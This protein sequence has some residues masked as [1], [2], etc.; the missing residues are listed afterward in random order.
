MRTA[1]ISPAILLLAAVACAEPEPAPESGARRTAEA[2]VVD[3][4]W[5]AELRRAMVRRQI[6]A[7]GVR[8]E[9]VLRAMRTVPR[10]RFVPGADAASA[11]G[12]RP[13]PIGHGQTISQPYIVAFMAEAADIEPGDRVLEIGTGS[14]YGAAV[15]AELAGEVYTIEIVPELAARAGEVLAREGY[16]NVHVRAGNGWLGW[17][18]HAP[19]DAIVV[20]AAPERVPPA[21]VEQLA[22]GGALVIPVGDWVQ[23]LRVLRKTPDGLREEASLPVRFVPMVGEPPDTGG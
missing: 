10:H 4:V 2:G 22:V 12:D 16:A 6:E 18:E 7:R 23:T 21:L 3:T 11:Y 14:G 17:P 5:L 8:D 19:Y 20:T 13:L 15:L 1:P 9:A